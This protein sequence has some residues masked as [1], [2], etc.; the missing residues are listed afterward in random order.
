MY[1]LESEQSYWPDGKLWSAKILGL[2]RHRN[3]A[4]LQG[5]LHEEYLKSN[6]VRLIIDTLRVIMLIRMQHYIKNILMNVKNHIMC[7]PN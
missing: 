3:D 2:I 5:N 7:H 6:F 4:V 1:T